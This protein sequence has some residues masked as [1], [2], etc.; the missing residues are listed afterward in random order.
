MFPVF[1]IFSIKVIN[2]RVLIAGGGG[3]INYG[4]KNGMVILDLSTYK[5]YSYLETEDII[6]HIDVQDNDEFTVTEEQKSNNQSLGRKC[7]DEV[8]KYGARLYD[9]LEMNEDT[10]FSI[11]SDHDKELE[12]LLVAIGSVNFYVVSLKNSVLRIM[13]KIRNK[14]NQVKFNSILFYTIDGR[15]Y[16]TDKY[17]LEENKECNTEDRKGD[18]N[19]VEEESDDEIREE[20]KDDKT[21]EDEQDSKVE[22]KIKGKGKKGSTTGKSK[23]RNN[24]TRHD[25]NTEDNKLNHDNNKTEDNN[26]TDNN[27]DNRRY[28]NNTEE[29]FEYDINIYN[30]ELYINENNNN[31]NDFY[32]TENKIYKITK[33]GEYYTFIFNKIKYKIKNKKHIK[34]NGYLIITTEESIIFMSDKETPQNEDIEEIILEGRYPLNVTVYNIPS[35][36]SISQI[37]L[38]TIVGT[39]KGKAHIFYEDKFTRKESIENMPITSIVYGND[40]IYYSTFTGAIGRKWIGSS[41]K[42]YIS[43]SIL[44][45]FMALL[46]ML[47]MGKE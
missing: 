40:Y 39:A 23:K 24:K 22:E 1:P 2:G 30:K 20:K 44:G 42:I 46:V 18:K 4:K 15:L 10:D 34:Y 16:V 27:N 19:D 5:E 21:E 29:I 43:V 7:E 36:T 32:I 38:Y 3:D 13:Y 17:Y 9:P 41:W 33:I 37:G 25:S 12:S 11:F 14:V 35:I 47:F 8:F 31:W 26:N 6:T 28:N 45:V